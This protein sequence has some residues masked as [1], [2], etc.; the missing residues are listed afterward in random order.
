M[1]ALSAL[2]CATIDTMELYIKHYDCDI[3]DY[4][5]EF[6]NYLGINCEYKRLAE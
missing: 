5:N 1:K 2:D 3:L 4:Y 6:F